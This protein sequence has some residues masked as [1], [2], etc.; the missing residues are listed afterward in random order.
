[1]S[2]VFD[3]NTDPNDRKRRR[4]LAEALMLKATDAGPIASPWQGAAKMAQ[5]LMG[6]IELGRYDKQDREDR[7]YQKAEDAKY[8][9]GG[10]PVPGYRHRR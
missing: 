1:M 5:A 10:S 4:Q 2:Y 3:S 6:G 7:D 8:A 9:G